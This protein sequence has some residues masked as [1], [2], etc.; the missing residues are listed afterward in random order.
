MIFSSAVEHYIK[1][2]SLFESMIQ[3]IL[4]VLAKKIDFYENIQLS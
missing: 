1:S 2:E 3:S 4:E